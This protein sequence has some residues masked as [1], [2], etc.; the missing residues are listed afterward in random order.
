MLNL[1]QYCSVARRTVGKV[2]VHG[3][4][5]SGRPS[6]TRATIRRDAGRPGRSKETL[7]CSITALLGHNTA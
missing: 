6:R 3:L 7:L 5:Q 2:A 1:H 4:L